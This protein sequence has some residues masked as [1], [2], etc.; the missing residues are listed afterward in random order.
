MGTDKVHD[1]ASVFRALSNDH[2]MSLFRTIAIEK[3]E[4]DMLRVKPN[5]KTILFKNK[6][7]NKVQFGAKKSRN[8]IPYFF[9][10]ACLQISANDRKRTRG[11]VKA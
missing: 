1:I 8:V 2:A 5:L 11:F 6:R 4:P 10:Q 3:K 7:A 9:W